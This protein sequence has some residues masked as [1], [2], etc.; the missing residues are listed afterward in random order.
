MYGSQQ[1]KNDATKIIPSSNKEFY[2]HAVDDK[3]KYKNTTQIKK[4]EV[5]I[6][7][8]NLDY[9]DEGLFQ[10]GNFFPIKG[11]ESH[12]SPNCDCFIVYIRSGGPKSEMDKTIEWVR[13]GLVNE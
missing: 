10:S 3:N 7:N 1:N 4:V 6:L 2:L 12:S 9:E 8:G 13:D 11:D 5:K